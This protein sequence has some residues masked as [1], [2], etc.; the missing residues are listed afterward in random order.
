MKLGTGINGFHFIIGKMLGC[1]IL[2][3]RGVITRDFYL[4]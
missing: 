3:K 2:L 1:E 4:R